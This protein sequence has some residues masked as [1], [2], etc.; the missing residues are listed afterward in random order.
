MGLW[1]RGYIWIYRHACMKQVCCGP[2]IHR[3]RARDTGGRSRGKRRSILGCE[4]LPC[5]RRRERGVAAAAVALIG[6]EFSAASQDLVLKANAPRLV[7]EYP[8]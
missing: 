3:T 5:A 8:P 6:V 2:A 7:D 4:S 1:I